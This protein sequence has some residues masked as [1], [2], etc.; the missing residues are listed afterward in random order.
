MPHKKQKEESGDKPSGEGS[1]GGV[2]LS[3]AD[4]GRTSP[5]RLASYTP[6]QDEPA[7]TTQPAGM[8]ESDKELALLPLGSRA[9]YVVTVTT[10]P[11]IMMIYRLTPTSKE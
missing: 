9:T 10:D 4:F 8:S 1:G 3:P 2:W 7:P 5:F 6:P 11:D